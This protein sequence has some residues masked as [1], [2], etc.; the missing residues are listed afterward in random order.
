MSRK[1]SLASILCAIVTLGA[2]SALLAHDGPC[3]YRSVSGDWG[4]TTDG[5]RNGVGLV[6]GAGGLTL[7]RNGNVSNGAQTVSF[8][9]T[10]AEETF[11]GTY[12]LNSDCTASMTVDVV[13]PI[14]PRTSHLNLIFVS[15]SNGVLG[16]FADDGTILT[17]NGKKL[18][19]G[20]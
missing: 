11:S 7:D 9:G 3:T 10:I 20:R 14:A 5:T 18:A 8:A 1:L 15:D 19:P 4:Y 13:S 6:A 2:S 17:V 16:I 12:T